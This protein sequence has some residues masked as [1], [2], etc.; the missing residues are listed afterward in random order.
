MLNK[1]T[2]LCISMSGRPSN[3][4][5]RFHN[6]LYAELGLNFVYKAFAPT[7][8]AQAV[9]GIRGL[10]IRGAA[11]SMPF[12]ESVIPML[13]RLEDS[14]RAIDSVNTIVNDAGVLTGYNTDY[15]AVASLLS[16]HEVDVRLPIAVR[17][18]GGMGKAVVAACRDAGF[19]S[20]TVVARNETTGPALAAQY[21]WEYSPQA[22]TGAKVLVNVTPIGMDGAQEAEQLSFT[23]DEVARAEVVFDVVAMPSETPLI[24]LARQLGKP[25]ITG[26]EVIALQAAEQ[27]V[28][29][30]GVRPSDEQVRAASEFSRQPEGKA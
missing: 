1:D 18:S 10:P 29:Y 23:Q 13:D 27:F 15:T 26:A 17:G 11:V 14:A 21:G 6:R 25:V 7:D 4:G 30:T 20:G 16:R 9:A 3:I 19:T 24:R 22:P 12:K 28:L 5:T 2:Q 8:L